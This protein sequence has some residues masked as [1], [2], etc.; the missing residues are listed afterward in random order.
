MKKQGAHKGRPYIM[1]GIQ[2]CRAGRNV[3]CRVVENG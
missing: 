2:T 3:G 1:P